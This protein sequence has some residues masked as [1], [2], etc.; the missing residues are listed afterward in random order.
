VGNFT[1][2][3]STDKGFGTVSLKNGKPS[4][5]VVYG[6]IPV[7]EVLVSGKKAKLV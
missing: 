2:F 1:S 6:S 7:K 4:L 5:N 3:L